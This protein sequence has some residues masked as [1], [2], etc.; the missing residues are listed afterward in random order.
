MA[1]VDSIASN[2]NNAPITAA[3]F[4]KHY[5]TLYRVLN[6]SDN[7]FDRL[8]IDLY[9]MGFISQHSKVSFIKKRDVNGLLD[10]ILMMN[11]TRIDSVVN[12]M[13]SIDLLCDIAIEMRVTTPHNNGN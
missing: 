9:S 11:P 4:R 5:A 1:S 6:T 10:Q 12:I 13:Y 7:A 8:T 2:S 3:V